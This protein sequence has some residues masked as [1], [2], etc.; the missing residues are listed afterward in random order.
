MNDFSPTKLFDLSGF[1]HASIFDGCEYA[2]EALPKIHLF[3][4][5]LELG[6]I[7]SPVPKEAHLVNPELITIESGCLIDPGV[8]IK[9][10]CYLGRGTEVRFGAYIR[11]DVIAGEGV[12][13]GHT[14][15]VK[16]SILLNKAHAAHFAYVGDSILG[17]GVNLGAGTKLANLKLTR[18]QVRVRHKGSSIATNLRKFGA[19]LA[20]GAQTGCNCVTNPGTIMGR[21]SSA[22]PCTNIGGFIPSKHIFNHEGKLVAMSV[23]HV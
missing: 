19:I 10:P 17:C 21:D 18:S 2:W 14:T 9:G 6:R 22:F 12:V 4:E 11:G 1:K 7:E 3:L 8:Y 5:G 15:E 13:I 16:N 20:D 23:H